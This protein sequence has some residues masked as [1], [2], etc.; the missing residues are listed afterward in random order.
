MV[1]ME[2]IVATFAQMA[3]TNSAIRTRATVFVRTVAGDNF[4][5]RHVLC[6]VVEMNVILTQA[7]V[8]TVVLD[9]MDYSVTM[10]VLLGVKSLVT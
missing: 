9:T 8:T 4:V 3:V 7:I 2:K 5:N 10:N 6:S 1:L